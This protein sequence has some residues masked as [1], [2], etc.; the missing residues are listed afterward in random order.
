MT[1]GQRNKLRVE[2]LYEKGRKRDKV[3]KG[4]KHGKMSII[5]SIIFGWSYTSSSSSSSD[6]SDTH[7]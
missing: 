3:T 4:K 6:S 5:L 1:A 2:T 7:T